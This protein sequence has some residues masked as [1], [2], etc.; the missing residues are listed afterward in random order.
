MKSLKKKLENT[1]IGENK[2][3]KNYE[4]VKLRTKMQN[5]GNF[6]CGEDRVINSASTTFAHFALSLKVIF[7]VPVKIGKENILFVYSKTR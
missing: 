2:I 5:S 4:K 6:F 1:F 3:H 7:W